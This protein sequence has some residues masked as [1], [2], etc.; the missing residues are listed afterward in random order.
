MSLQFL[1]LQFPSPQKNKKMKKQKKIN[2]NRKLKAIGNT[3]PI[4][5]HFRKT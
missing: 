2:N 4:K 3:N 1:K 5:E